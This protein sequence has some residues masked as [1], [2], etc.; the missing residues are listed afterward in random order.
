VEREVRID[1]MDDQQVYQN[2]DEVHGNEQANNE[3]LYFW[4]ICVDFRNVKK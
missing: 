3:K 2:G 4:I 1:S